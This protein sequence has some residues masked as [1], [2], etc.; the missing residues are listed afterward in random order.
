M[1]QET[2]ACI[3]WLTDWDEALKRAAAARRPIFL[4]LWKVG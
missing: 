3:D 4:D 1:A 2:P